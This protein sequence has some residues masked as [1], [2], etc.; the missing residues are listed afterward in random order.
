M[1]KIDFSDTVFLNPASY[2]NVRNETKKKDPL[3]NK[4]QGKPAVGSSPKPRFFDVL[5]ETV[6]EAAGPL[7]SETAS[8]EVLQEL[9]D[10][11]HSAGDA[12]KTRPFPEEI[13]R[14]KQA[15]RG[16]IHYVVENGYAVEKQ[17]GIPNYL[18]PGFKGQ[19]GSDAAKGRTGFHLIQVVDRK[20]EQLATGILAGQTSQLE[21]L[22][23]INEIAGILIDLLH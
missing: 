9:L 22:A 13:R 1:A 4:I 23:R 16:F 11:V 2:A 12:L 17:T 21:L 20:L 15:V 19:R 14:Y 18:K 5:E 8:E 3:K 7:P 10:D 6:R